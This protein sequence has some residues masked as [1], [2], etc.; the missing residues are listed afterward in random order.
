MSEGASLPY[1]PRLAEHA[2][3]RRHVVDGREIV[4]IHDTRSGNLVRT[5]SREW[6]I[7]AQADG[8][9]EFDGILLAAARKG[10]LRRASEVRALLEQLHAAGLLANGI[11]HAAPAPELPDRPLDALP[12]FSLTCDE[13]GVCCGMYGSIVFTPIEAARARALRPDVLDGGARPDR[14]FLPEHGA[15]GEGAVAVA[16]IDGR[17]AYLAEGGRCS[18]HVA[19]GEGAKPRG[20]R[21]YP[22]TFV[23][24]GEAV[25]VSVGVECPC[26]L[27]SVGR[28]GGA[29]LVPAGAKSARDL[30]EGARVVALPERIAIAAARTAPRGDFVAWSRL[31]AGL[32]AVEVR[33]READVDAVSV[34]WSLGAALD[35]DGLF[36]DAARAAI[37]AP[38]RPSEDLVRLWAVALHERAVARLRSAEA[39]R[40]ER[41]RSRT[42]SRWLAEGAA[43]LIAP[44]GIL[45][46]LD[47]PAECARSEAFYVAAALHGHHLVDELPVAAAARDRAARLLVARLLPA[48]IPADDPAHAHPIALVESMMRGHGMKAYARDVAAGPEPQAIPT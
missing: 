24:D 12:G 43:A 34:L 37:H 1:R 8:T 31:V 27:A 36:E 22:A 47:R 20:C 26:V 9:R 6:E 16:Q 48:A 11:E 39:W 14:V 5:G 45:A 35:R 19:A 17:C 23:D 30:G 25:R 21:T 33:E 40:S 29:P 3:A 46:A 38:A 18:L 28:D 2:L 42:A 44:G 4:V 32:V 41:D 13:S 7:L 10:A 15:G